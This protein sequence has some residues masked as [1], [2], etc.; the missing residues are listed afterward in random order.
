VNRL[1]AAG[2]IGVGNTVTAEFAVLAPGPAGNPQDQQ[3]TP[4]GVEQRLGAASKIVKLV[5]VRAVSAGRCAAG[6]ALV[7]ANSAPSARGGL[8]SCGEQ[9]RSAQSL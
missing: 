8:R 1:D 6:T 3:H 4:G 7:S 9:F 5:D 2:A